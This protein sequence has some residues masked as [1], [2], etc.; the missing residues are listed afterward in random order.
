MS[1]IRRALSTALV[2][3]S[4][5]ASAGAATLTID[6]NEKLTGATDVDVLGILYSVEFVNGSCAQVYSGCDETSDFAFTT[7]DQ[8]KAASQAIL[9]LFVGDY[10]TEPQLTRG[11]TS[12]SR[13]TI[14]TPIQ[15]IP[16][17]ETSDNQKRILFYLANNSED[18]RF[19]LWSRDG[20]SHYPTRYGTWPNYMFS[21]N[22]GWLLAKWT[23][24][25]PE[26]PASPVPLPAGGVLMLTALVAAFSVRRRRAST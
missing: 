3:G 25:D 15:I 22:G 24:Q 7:M 21:G 9:D 19:A 17:S 11:V 5:A 8:G 23:K 4:L 10:D 14:F 12:D 2:S 1:F 16:A 13:V 6:S 20:V 18:G 26:P